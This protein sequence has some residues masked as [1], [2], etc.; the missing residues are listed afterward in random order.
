MQLADFACDDTPRAVFPLFDEARG[1]ST[2]AVLI[3]GDMPVVVTTGALGQTAHL[4]VDWT[5]SFRF[6]VV[7]KRPIPYGPTVRRTKEIP[8][9][10]Y[11]VF[12]VPVA[13]V[14][15]LFSGWSLLFIDR[16]VVLAVMLRQVR[17]EILQVQFL[18]KFDVPVV[19]RQVCSVL[20]V[21]RPWRSHRCCSWLCY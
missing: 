2:G 6:P 16:V 17:V 15:H 3:Q 1:D 14:V 10:L 4:A 8:L 20:S 9:L 18:D 5:R 13:Q 12:V 19:S 21:Y 7:V 11:T